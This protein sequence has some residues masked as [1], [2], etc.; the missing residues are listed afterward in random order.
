M[1]D[2]NRE[3]LIELLRLAQSGDRIAE[4]NLIMYIRDNEMQ[5]RISKYLRRN[6][7]VEDEDLKQEFLIGVALNISK[8]D[9]E[10]G[11]PIEY[12]ISQGVFRV[13]SYLRKHIIQNTTQVCSDCGYESRLNRVKNHQYE[14]KKCGSHNIIT[15][16][17]SDHD[18]VAL[19]NKC[20][21][22][23][24]IEKLIEGLGAEDIIMRFRSTLD[25]N[26]KMY[27][28]FVLLYDEDIN[29][30]NPEI[31]NYIKEIANR[32]GTSQT[33]VIQVKEK[34]KIKLLKFCE[35]EKIDI[36]HNKFT[37]RED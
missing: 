35:S 27:N 22:D 30:D 16:E 34:L 23:D 15:R 20:A 26:T 6:R 25:N 32:W 9:L 28:L 33:L 36:K 3:Y 8:A 4:N 37:Y 21:D 12:I 17:I 10:I 19:E 5:K 1:T 7:Q 18:E 14:C 29:S 13:R 31:D 11:N 2:T 24:E